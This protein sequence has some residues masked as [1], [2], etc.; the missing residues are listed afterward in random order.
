[1]RDKGEWEPDL[2]MEIG[3]WPPHVLVR[4]RCGKC[5]HTADLPE[6]RIKR[7]PP[8]LPAAELAKRLSCSFCPQG[9]GTGR[10]AIYLR[11]KPRN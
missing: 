11:K 7:L 5:G 2:E 10:I 4:A 3:S 1:M 8:A 9:K 6:Q